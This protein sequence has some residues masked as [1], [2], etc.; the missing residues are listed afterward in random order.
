MSTTSAT[1]PTI[2]VVD[3]DDGFRAS[4]REMFEA[5]GY[6]VVEASNGREAIETASGECPDI[7]V[8][9]L[10]MPVMDGLNASRQLRKEGGPCQNTPILAI[11]A[12]G[13]EMRGL[14]LQ[15]G[16]TDYFNKNEAVRM[17]MVLK[18][19]LKNR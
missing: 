5:Y 9:D 15:A 2:L 16:C 13:F 6:Q 10:N 1:S 17:I 7:I 3:D 12:N 4:L 19:I 8:M 11:S 18:D 14:A